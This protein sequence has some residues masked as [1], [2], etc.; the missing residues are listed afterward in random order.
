MCLIIYLKVKVKI[1]RI[2]ILT[3]V[4]YA[5][6]LTYAVVVVQIRYKCIGNWWSHIP[7]L[8]ENGSPINNLYTHQSFIF[9]FLF[10]LSSSTS[11]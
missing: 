8:N 10:F 1:L 9:Y 11:G 5:I 7:Y 3:M 4:Q 6:L 2:I